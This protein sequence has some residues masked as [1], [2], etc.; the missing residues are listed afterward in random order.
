MNRAQSK[1]ASYFNFAKFSEGVEQTG[2]VLLDLSQNADGVRPEY[3]LNE[4]KF[5]EVID[6][7]VDANNERFLEQRQLLFLF[8][9]HANYLREQTNY[10]GKNGNVKIF[11]EVYKRAKYAGV[12]KKYAE[13]L[14]RGA[15]YPSSMPRF[16][17]YMISQANMDKSVDALVRQNM[18]RDQAYLVVNKLFR[19]M[20]EA[21]YPMYNQ[22]LNT[23]IKDE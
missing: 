3:F 17:P 11:E 8:T 20:E 19:T 5:V 4:E 12:P 16:V 13:P 15:V 21:V 10:Q 2:D 18:P 6:A 23:R 7:F 9:A 22:R 1:F 14:V